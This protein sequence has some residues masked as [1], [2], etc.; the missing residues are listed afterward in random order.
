M[1]DLSSVLWIGGPPGAGKTTVARLIA[2]RRGLRWYNAD[3]HTWEHRDRAIAAGHPAAIRWEAMTPAERWSASPEDMIAMSLHE[4]RGPMIVDDLRALPAAPLTI[5]EGTPITPSAAGA[6]ARAV[7]LL[8]SPEVREARLATRELT[9][10]VV[11][12]YRS[13][14]QVIEKEVVEYGATTLVV[15]GRR[16]IEET[17][18]DVERIFADALDTGPVAT[19]PQERRRL[20]RYANR[21][22]VT[23]HLTF[24]ARPWASGDAR[25]AVRA[26]DCECGQ[27]GCDEQVRLA[28]ADFPALPVDAEP[29]LAP[30]H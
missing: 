9:P 6:E 1:G 17:V 23:Q 18:A 14:A 26:F 19:T 3:V 5:A 27:D 22:V 15:D 12:L 7:W 21:A 29:V 20:L 25:S 13:L 24:F 28:I 10:G 8:P 16:G 2:R 11:D 30:G 4:E